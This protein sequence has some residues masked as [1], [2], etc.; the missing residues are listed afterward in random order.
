MTDIPASRQQYGIHW[1]VAQATS[2]QNI[3]VNMSEDPGTQHWG[4]FMENGSGGFVSDL[5]F[6]GGVSTFPTSKSH[7]NKVSNSDACH[8]PVQRCLARK[9]AV[10]L[11]QLDGQ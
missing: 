8:D 7:E 9:S 2:L 1:Q 10:H 5:I 3:V 4:I 6:N 11:P